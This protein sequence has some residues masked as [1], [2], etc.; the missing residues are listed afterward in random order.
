MKKI[1][2]PKKYKTVKPNIKES[3]LQKSENQI[4]SPPAQFIQYS[5]NFSKNY[6]FF[7]NKI[8]TKTSPN[9]QIKK[10]RRFSQNDNLKPLLEET[11]LSINILKKEY[12]KYR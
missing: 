10:Q 11:E 4:K 5:E 7:S 8:I 12:D 9:F 2:S 1:R 6:E 3:I